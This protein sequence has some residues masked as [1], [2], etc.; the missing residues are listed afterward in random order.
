MEFFKK[1]PNIRFMELRKYWYVLSLVMVLGSA[2]LIAVPACPTANKSY[3]DSSGFG[4]P[5]IDPFFRSRS[6]CP[7]RP[8]IIL[9]A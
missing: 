7:A 4:N 5:L 2:V 1:I 6:N 9:C 3:A 8:V